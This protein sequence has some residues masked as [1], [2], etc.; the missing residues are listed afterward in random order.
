MGRPNGDDPRKN[1]AMGADIREVVGGAIG[2]GL[3]PGFVDE[4]VGRAIH[5]VCAEVWDQATRA[6]VIPRMN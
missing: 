6:A 2:N 3:G 4:V 5:I 1:R